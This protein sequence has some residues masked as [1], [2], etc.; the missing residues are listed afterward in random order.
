[1]S[2]PYT[3]NAVASQ[4]ATATA[5]KRARD[6]LKAKGHAYPSFDANQ[7]VEA[8]YDA[9]NAYSKMES[10]LAVRFLR[11]PSGPRPIVLDT[12]KSTKKEYNTPYLD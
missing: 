2:K 11:E 6:T 8:F 7:G 1:M 9:V 10:E 3:S 4:D 12:T 5:I